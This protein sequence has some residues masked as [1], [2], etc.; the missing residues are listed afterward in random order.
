LSPT[1]C[2]SQSFDAQKIITKRL[3]RPQDLSGTLE[4]RMTCY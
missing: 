3:K 1:K 4:K 2:A